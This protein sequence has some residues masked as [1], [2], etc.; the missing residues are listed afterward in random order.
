MFYPYTTVILAITLDGKVADYQKN[1]ARFGSNNDKLHLEHQI[2]LSDA[3]L[4]G[5][6]T[7]RA[8]QTSLPITTSSL[9]EKRRQHHK[10]SQPIHLVCSA[11]GQLNPQWRFFQQPIPRWL[12]T[13]PAGQKNW[14]QHNYQGFEQIIAS[15]RVRDDFDWSHI[16]KHLYSCHIERLAILGG[17]TL[18]ASLLEAD[19]IDE[20]Q[21]TLCPVILGG[22]NAPT[23][24][25]GQGF[26]AEKAKKLE[27]LSIKTISSEIF[28][29]YRKR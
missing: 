27:L 12:L 5:A 23:L 15:E 18:I 17:G 9:L 22:E 16:F 24:V 19:L 11:S 8:Y 4:F 26:L 2:S 20:W 25:E 28:L 21:I 29:H 14:N 10:P 3:V 6:G 13:T 1:A 7:L